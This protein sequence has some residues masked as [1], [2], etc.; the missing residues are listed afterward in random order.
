MPSEAIKYIGDKLC[1]GPIDFSFL[2]AIPAIP[3][4]AV[5]NGPV[6]IGT[7]GVPIPTANCMIGPGLLTPVTLQVTGISN[8]I[9]VT[10]ITG[11]VNRYAFTSASGVTIKTGISLK[12]ALAASYGLS[13]KAGVQ[14]TSGPK[15]CSSITRTPL[16]RADVGS[17]GTCQASLG[18]FASVAAPFKFFDIPHPNKSG[19]RLTHACL[20]GPE[21]GVY[22][23]GR[24]IDN[25]VIE[26][27]DYWGN[28]IDIESITVNLTSH[29]Y[30]QELYVKNIESGKKINIVNNIGSSIDCSYIIYAE[31][32][33]VDKLLLEYKSDTKNHPYPEIC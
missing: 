17:F 2:P 11:V 8:I 31:R 12:K 1:V 16:I 22:H 10:N 29:T 7:G 30:Y 27:P 23:R 3:G 6:W 24:L 4:S 14:I 32:I 9:G 20:E 13:T 15:L 18:V 5:L 26:L 33:D 21:I 19:Y 25:N 28:L